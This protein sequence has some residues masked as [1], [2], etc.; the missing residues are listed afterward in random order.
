[1]TTLLI[2]FI[3]IVFVCGACW[4][5][6]TVVPEAR[7]AHSETAVDK[8]NAVQPSPIL[9]R[10]VLYDDVAAAKWAKELSGQI[11]QRLSPDFK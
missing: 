7:L 3:L 4:H 11:I 2:L 6:K 1:M 10:M 5:N 8:Q 9:D